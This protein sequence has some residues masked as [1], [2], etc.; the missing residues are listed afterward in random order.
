MILSLL[1]L[2]HPSSFL[3]PLPFPVPFHSLS[4]LAKHEYILNLV[5]SSLNSYLLRFLNFACIF[6]SPNSRPS[7]VIVCVLLSLSLPSLSSSVSVS[8]VSRVNQTLIKPYS[9]GSGR[10]PC[11]PGPRVDSLSSFSSPFLPSSSPL[12]SPHSPSHLSPLSSFLLSSLSP[13]I[14]SPLS[15]S[16]PF[17]HPFPAPISLHAVFVSVGCT[18]SFFSRRWSSACSQPRRTSGGDFPL[19]IFRGAS[20]RD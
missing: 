17:T 19:V 8:R 16:P 2:P 6:F 20:T 9:D 1:F 14:I 10:G 4:S 3:T 15:R 12:L 5:Y 7:L 11:P 18:P 13:S